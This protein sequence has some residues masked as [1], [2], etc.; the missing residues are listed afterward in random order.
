[1]E[2]LTCDNPLQAIPFLIQTSSSSRVRCAEASSIFRLRSKK[3]NI[4]HTRLRLDAS[5]LN[6]HLFK[7]Q[8]TKTSTP[9][10]TC[11]HTFETT[12]HFLLYCQLYNVKR[13]TMETSIS[14]IITSF[15]TST[16]QN[17]LNILLNGQGLSD[18]DGLVVAR[19]VQ[20][21][22]LDTGRFR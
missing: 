16:P 14:A 15:S 5:E 12:K 6:A 11:R 2:Q 13:I 7:I 19:A 3:S 20:K 1:M 8:S 21:Y 17:K 9:Y 10:C 22:I 18:A 4:L